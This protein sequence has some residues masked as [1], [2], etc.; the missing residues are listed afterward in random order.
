MAKPEKMKASFLDKALS[1]KPR[2]AGKPGRPQSEPDPEEQAEQQ[3]QAYI[4][5]MNPD[6]VEHAFERMLDDMNLTEEKK[7]PLR[8]Q[9]IEKKRSM[10]SMHSKGSAPR[11]RSRFVSPHD[12]IS[13]L[14]QPDLSVQKTYQCV[15]SLRIALTNNPLT[16]VQEF[17]TKGLKQLLSVLNECYRG[18]SKWDRIQLECVRCL[19]S[20]MNSTVGLK[21]MLEQKEAL[22]ILA[23]SIDPARPQVMQEAVRIMAALAIVPPRGHAC[24][25]EAITISGE[26]NQRERFAPIVQGLMDRSNDQ[27]RVSTLLLINSLVS[28]PDD[29][30]FRLHLRN[31]FMR[32]GLMDILEA[33]ESEQ[34]DDLQT[35][36]KVFTEHRDDDYE[37]FCQRFDNIKLELDDMESCIELLKNTAMNSACEPY[38]LSIVQHMLCIR[39]DHSVRVAYFK[40]IEECVS[41]IV[42]HKSGVDP[43]FRATKRFK[44]DVEPLIETVVERSRQEE[45]RASGELNR[46]LDELL[47]SKQET[48]A[49]LASTERRCRELE[50]R[51]ASGAGPPGQLQIPAGMPGTP[52]PI[53]LP[54][55]MKPKKK[56]SLAKNLKRANWKKVMPQHLKENSFW[57]G[58]NEE[59]LADEDILEG[60][61]N[62]FSSKPVA[63]KMDTD[64]ANAKT[65][66]T[67]E[68]RVLDGKAAQNLSILLGGPLK[69]MSYEDVKRAILRCDEEVLT[70]TLTESLIQYCP[71]PDQ[72]KK[73][74]NYRAEY[75]G[76]YRGGAVRH[77][78]FLLLQIGSIKRL[79][80]RLKSMSFKL[81]FAEMVQDVKPAIVAATA[82]CEEIMSSKK[83]AR[84]LELILLMGNYMNTGS[85]NAQAVGF[86]I[87]YIAKL[88]NTKDVENRMTLLH[89][90][91]EVV[92]K[93]H[94]ELLSFM[95]EIS[96][97]E[98][99]SKV[100]EEQVRKNMRQ[101]EAATK[102]LET[103]LKN[104]KV[105]LS[106]D[107]KF[108]DVMTDFA[109]QARQ[110]VDIITTMAEKMSE[111][112]SKIADYYVFD[113]QK[114]VM[115]DFF[116]DV[117]TFVNHFQN[118][119][120]DNLKLRETE[121]KI[122]RAREA[123]AKAERERS[124]KQSKKQA[125]EAMMNAPD[126]QEGVMDS[127]LE[128][129]KSGSAFSREQKKKRPPRAA[130]ARANRIPMGISNEDERD[131][132]VIGVR[133]RSDLEARD[134]V[135]DTNRIDETNKLLQ[136]VLELDS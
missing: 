7:T 125:I 133:K 76:P 124:E 49:L 112:F 102:N 134:R 51:I 28:S 131:H 69:H 56:W 47:T 115:E 54:Y 17:G 130:G 94:P 80:P 12:Y 78:A 57:V 45:E 81:R 53:Q 128:A 77:H 39:D 34:V 9:D 100:S 123:K 89:Y 107:D 35:Q 21:Q 1:L 104:N 65:K 87:S 88:N 22:T 97:V 55:G 98:R 20:I 63:V 60:L 114:Y 38:L 10:L 44:L 30:D 121:A 25:L 129:L 46:R 26:F 110:Q 103:D 127:L 19:K 70:E 83:F 73:L 40:L 58:I 132:V 4:M 79:L 95:D 92:E 109:V 99:A 3:H 24:T 108:V 15:E 13:Y 68:L 106:P 85:Q 52:Q 91:A 93:K 96:H 135:R 11:Q 18:D 82:A 5:S 36:L 126:D 75:D 84:M 90:L 101:M 66:R 16:W 33:M 37:E 48:E 111:L 119:Y 136:R 2:R 105:A 43:D 29:L 41:Q 118:A 122:E 74:E 14:G 86:E 27:L 64:G 72:L 67:K 71:T 31:E 50:A 117:N 23:R 62:R 6:E 116:G 32:V 120:K 42:L 59:R 61:Q 113:K 8:I